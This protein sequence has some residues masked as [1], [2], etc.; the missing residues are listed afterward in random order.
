MRPTWRYSLPLNLRPA[1][2]LPSHEMSPVFIAVLHSW[3]IPNAATFA[4]VVVAIIYIRGWWL[5]RRS[6]LPRLS[7]WRAASFLGGLLALWVALASPMDVFNGFVLTAH[8]LQHMTLMMVAPPLILLGE[9]LIPLVRGLP[10]FA[11]REFAGPLLNWTPAQVLGR[12]LVSPLFAL[13]LMGLVN[14][15]WHTPRLYQLALDSDSWHQVEHACFFLASL[16]FWWPVVQPWPS[17]AQWPRWAMVPYLLVAD[18]QNTALSAILV[19]SDR[20]L[21]PWYLDAP[22]LFDFSAQQDQAAAGAIMWV[23]GSLAFVVPAVI[24]AVQCLSRRN[25]VP[26]VKSRVTDDSVAARMLSSLESGLPVRFFAARLQSRR[27]QAI[28]FAFLF[29]A[30]GLCFAY[31][32]AAPS[33]DDQVLRSRRRSDQLDVAVYGPGGDIPIGSTAFSALVQD[34]TSKEVLLDS[35]VDFTLQK[36]GAGRASPVKVRA[37][38]EGSENKLL[39]SGEIELSA[40]GDWTLNVVAQHDAAR[41]EFSLPLHVVQPPSDDAARWPYM[42]F[43]ATSIILLMV[44]FWR[45][46]LPGKCHRP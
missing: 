26:A 23:V 27:A 10:R 33:D 2:P 18:L 16:L 19:F 4:L 25:T 34:S 29:G 39:Q 14:F 36:I 35:E 32:L 20:V 22:R 21:Y 37:K 1:K 15:A 8:M 46:L 38:R 28:A 42:A 17:Q 30:T 45:H 31:L 5:L 3:A 40:A 7:P 6:G 43:A 44:Y 41:S 9:P 12:R 11:A 13:V 24:I